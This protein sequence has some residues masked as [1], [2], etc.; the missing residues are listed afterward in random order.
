VRV[1]R[2]DA[3]S[4]IHSDDE[5]VD[6][7]DLAAG[8]RWSLVPMLGMYQPGGSVEVNDVNAREA[9]VFVLSG[10]FELRFVG[11]P[12]VLLRRGE[13]AIYLSVAPYR[14]TNVGKA[15]GRI[16]ALGLHPQGP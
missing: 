16:L 1:L 7:F 3:D 13:G 11:D 2:A 4:M 10:T 9:M 12:P 5:G 15:P 14:V 6:V 8:S